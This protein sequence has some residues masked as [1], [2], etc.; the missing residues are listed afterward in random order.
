MNLL[1]LEDTTLSKDAVVQLN[2]R[3]AEH[4]RTV[5]RAKKGDT[6]KTGVLGGKIGTSEI[7]E[8]ERGKASIRIL[9]LETEP[10]EKNLFTPIIALPRPQSFKKCLHFIASSGIAKAFFIM[11][12]RVEK[13][14]LESDA[15]K[16]MKNE[17]MLGLEQGVD[18]IPPE[19]IILKDM[20]KLFDGTYTLPQTRF[21][22]H[23]VNAAACPYAL[24]EP[25]T[26]A[27]GPEGGFIQKEIDAFEHNSFRR[28]HIGKHIL[29]VEFALSYLAGRMI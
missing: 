27:I 16:D 28:V 11:T 14:Y 21:I 5:L 6:V 17:I 29:R 4:I 3:Q 8:T 25:F 19:I 23:P 9:G 13:S 2:A 22:A 1:L 24:E 10:P 7:L 20:R 12:S 18:T 26:A 15:V